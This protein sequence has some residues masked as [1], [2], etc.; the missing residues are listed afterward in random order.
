M[1]IFLKNRIKM[2]DAEKNEN[3]QA[4]RSSKDSP[5]KTKFIDRLKSKR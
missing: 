1:N 5:N 2:V 4:K 3:I